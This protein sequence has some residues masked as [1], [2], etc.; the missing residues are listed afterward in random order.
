MKQIRL[1]WEYSLALAFLGIPQ[2]THPFRPL[3]EPNTAEFSTHQ[4]SLYF[5][6]GPGRCNGNQLPCSAD[7]WRTTV[8]LQEV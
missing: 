5:F 1:S 8:P 2:S 3:R 7:T 4:T 6:E